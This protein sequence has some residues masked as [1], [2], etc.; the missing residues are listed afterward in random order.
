MV[1]RPLLEQPSN[2]DLP[3]DGHS[4]RP[5]QGEPWTP[6]VAKCPLEVSISAV[7][8]LN[9]EKWTWLVTKSNVAPSRVSMDLEP[10]GGTEHDTVLMPRIMLL[11]AMP[12]GM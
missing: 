6:A 2:H 11:P 4:A 9:T 12:H 1:L 3:P 5:P 8:A 7:E 10:N